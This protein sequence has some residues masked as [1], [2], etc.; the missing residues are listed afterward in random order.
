MSVPPRRS[1]RSGLASARPQRQDECR[2]GRQE[3][4]RRTELALPP[5][6]SSPDPIQH[7]PSR[8]PSPCACVDPSRPARSGPARVPTWLWIEQG[9]R[10]TSALSTEDGAWRSDHVAPGIIRLTL[11]QLLDSASRVLDAAARR[12]AS[13]AQGQRFDC[14]SW[15]QTLTEDT[16]RSATRRGISTPSGTAPRTRPPRM[17]PMIDPAAMASTKPL[18]ARRTSKLRSRL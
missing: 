7:Y 17:V 13:N 2:H 5:A 16:R 12:Q 15:R 18:L 1:T 9:L 6:V 3:C 8:P 10:L 14:Q 11:A 4:D